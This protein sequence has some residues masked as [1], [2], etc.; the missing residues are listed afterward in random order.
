MG[1][2]S[3][4]MSDSGEPVYCQSPKYPAYLLVPEPFQEEY[5][6]YLEERDYEGYGEFGGR[7][8]Y[9]LVAQWNKPE[10]CKNP[11]GTWKSDDDCR[12]IGIDIACYDYQNK[13]LKYPIKITSQPMRYSSAE[14]SLSDDNQGWHV[15]EEYDD[16]W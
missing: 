14:P 5:G 4:L 11:D 3:W 2:F 1:Q 8:A 9:A 12:N 16:Y 6:S 10:L 13:S 15:E 7:D